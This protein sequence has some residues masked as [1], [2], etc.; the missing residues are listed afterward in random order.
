MNAGCILAFNLAN[1]LEI[2]GQFLLLRKR[3][4]HELKFIIMMKWEVSLENSVFFSA[5]AFSLL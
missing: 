3:D 4:K 5:L 2:L 1:G